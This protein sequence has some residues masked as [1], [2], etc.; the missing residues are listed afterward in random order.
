M[1]PFL[2]P[3]VPTNLSS[4]SGLLSLTRVTV[5]YFAQFCSDDL[6]RGKHKRKLESH[7]ARASTLG[8]V[9]KKNGKLMMLGENLLIDRKKRIFPKLQLH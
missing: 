3:E 6:S 4:L 7:R 8:W 5:I 1:R 9:G 2:I